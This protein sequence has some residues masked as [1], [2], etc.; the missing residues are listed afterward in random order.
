MGRPVGTSYACD[1]AGRVGLGVYRE[2]LW[3][4]TVRISKGARATNP[5]EIPGIEGRVETSLVRKIFPAHLLRRA[6]SKAGPVPGGARRSKASA[7]AP[8]LISDGASGANSKG[9]A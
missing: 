7:L 1:G 6:K 2:L 9:G 3:T 8:R 5:W 4:S